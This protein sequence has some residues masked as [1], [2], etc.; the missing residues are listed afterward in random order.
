MAA[1]DA[2]TRLRAALHGQDGSS[3]V[4]AIGGLLIFLGFLFLAVQVTVH[5]YTISTAGTIALEAANRAAKDGGA[6]GCDR[7]RAWADSRVG[8]WADTVA[9]GET[10]DGQEVIVTI[11]GTSPV[12]SMRVFRA[13]T[14]LTSIHRS[15]RVRVEEGI[16][17]RT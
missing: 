12:A 4:T 3:P 2:V 17:A 14:G 1:D 11:T 10:L 15:A 13:A 9:C 8:N 16:D 6:P 5:L 7:A